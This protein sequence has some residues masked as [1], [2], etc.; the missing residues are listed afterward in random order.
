MEESNHED[1]RVA[2]GAVQTFTALQEISPEYRAT[3]RVL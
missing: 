3:R 1:N 2:G